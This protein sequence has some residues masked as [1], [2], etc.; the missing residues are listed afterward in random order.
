MFEMVTGK[1]DP[2]DAKAWF[3]KT[4]AFMGLGRFDDAYAALWKARENQSGPSSALFTIGA[5]LDILERVETKIMS[6]RRECDKNAG[7]PAEEYPLQEAPQGETPRDEPPASE[8][9]IVP[10]GEELQ[11]I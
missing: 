7:C 3:G 11:L 5:A 6:L 4:T 1:L 2:R 9:P 8:S 10:D